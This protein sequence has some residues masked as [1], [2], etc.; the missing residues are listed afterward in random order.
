[1]KLTKDIEKELRE[2][3]LEKRKVFKGNFLEIENVDVR[4][5]D[6]KMG[7]RDCI[8]HPGAVS[9]LAF[10]EKGEILLEYQYRT[11][12]DEV[13]CEIPAGKID[14][15]EDLEAAALREL[16]EETGYR[17]NK[18]KKIGEVLLAPG[19]CDEI[20]TIYKAED[21][22]KEETSFDEDERVISFFIGLDEVKEM[23]REGKIKDAKTL[24]SLL[25]LLLKA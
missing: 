21:L 22:V 4:L 11:P 17:A 3:I 15:G 18:I 25:F 20:L 7:N 1:M 13:I 14:K 9:I 5:P 12:V 24:S 8:R 19:Y 10:N 6:G 23:V 2:T 16:K